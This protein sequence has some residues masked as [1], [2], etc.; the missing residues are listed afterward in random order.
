M[1]DNHKQA[2]IEEAVELLT[3][4]E[5]SLLELEKAPE[6]QDIIARVF[7][8]LHTI[9]GSSGM[10]GYDDIS[11]FT[12]DIESIFDYIRNGQIPVTKQIIDLTLQA[13]DEIG[14]MLRHP[15]GTGSE[16]E[17]KTKELVSAFRNIVLNYQ[18]INE[19][20]EEPASKAKT[21]AVAAD[22]A[23]KSRTT[24]YVLFKPPANILMSGN[25]P[26]LLLKELTELGSSLV[27][28]NAEAI[29]ELSALNPEE[30]YVSWEIVLT[31]QHSQDAIRDVFI[32]VEDECQIQ[33]NTLD[34]T[35]I[36]DTGEFFEYIKDEFTSV[37]GSDVMQL[38]DCFK[39][40][41]KS[42]RILQQD[43]KTEVKKIREKEERHTEAETA[44]NIRVNAEKL[45][46]LVNLVGE[47][48]TVQAR[49]TQTANLSNMPELV[50]IAEE[51]ERLT[52]DLRDSALNM[53]MLPIGTTFSKFNRLVR[54]LSKEL[55]KEVELIT[56]GAETELDKTVIEK[57]NDPLVHIIRNS[58]DHGIELPQVRQSN[59]KNSRGLVR[60]SAAQA[61]GN[62]LIQIHDDGAGLDKELI[63]EKAVSKGIISIDTELTDNDIYTLIFAPGFSTAQKVT[64]V[65]GRGVGMDVVKQAIESLR[66]SIEVESRKNEGTTI[67]LKIPL[68][69]AI[70]DGLLVQISDDYYI[71]PL[72]AVEECI[73]LTRKDIE[74]THGRNLVN[75]RGEIVPFI[76]LRDTFG[77][78]GNEPEIE[79]VV[80]SSVN[81]GKVGFAVD[82]VIG[83]HQTV[84]KTLGK[85][86]KSVQGVSGATI[87][88]DG[89]VAL[90]LDIH[91]V[92][93]NTETAERIST[94]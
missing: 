8:A 75:I 64:N 15:E 39:N 80:I 47:L 93:Q 20:N 34:K 31:T 63:R 73:E 21:A 72:S 85:A 62:V 27:L 84:L 11:V 4:L 28:N 82:K 74:K 40:Q 78:R 77:I 36:L 51:V 22:A 86:F 32:F 19:F 65:S 49:L 79:Q 26:L 48:V 2:F 89:R 30:C 56:E 45:D 58:I 88:G 61:G 59:G 81:N 6:D 24:F 3:S 35:G 66:G 44:T 71:L 33:I 1:L 55:G 37:P 17:E 83:S 42:A 76:R 67:T 53:R 43:V 12:H 41:L 23:D 69:L 54:D 50:L 14:E 25:N 91:K 94:I 29:P 46:N 7:R 16:N 70:I 60:L 57:L 10:F 38:A 87:L 5:A 18:L 90:I 68:T 52:W 9:K 13:R 92:V